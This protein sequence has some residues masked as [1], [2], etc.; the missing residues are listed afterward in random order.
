[1]KNFKLRRS[2]LPLLAAG[3]TLV[4]LSGC[5]EKTE[6][7]KKENLVGYIDTN[8]NEVDP[9]DFIIYDGGNHSRAGKI[10]ATKLEK[11]LKKCKKLGISVGII[12]GSEA[13]IKEEIYE[14]VEFTK[15]IIE[16][17]NIDF[18]VYL[19]PKNIIDNKELSK[20]E[21]ADFIGEFLYLMEQNNIYAGLYGTSTDLQYI[22]ENLLPI[23]KYDSFI[24]EDG[25]EE[26]NGK[27]SVR[28]D[29]R[30]NIQSTY[31]SKEYNDNLAEMIEQNN[32]NRKDSLKQTGYHKVQKEETLRD[33]ADLHNLSESGILKFNEL[34]EDDIKPGITLRIPNELQNE[35]TLIMPKLQR[36]ERAVYRGIDIS[37][38]QDDA[39]NVNFSALRKKIDFII[40]KISEQEPYEN[41]P[42][43]INY[44]K[45]QKDDN[46]DDYYKCCIDNGILVGGYYVTRATTAEEARKE[47]QLVVN[48]IKNLK[49]SLPVFIDYENDKKYMNDFDKIK[50]N[51][52][53]EEILAVA[54]DIFNQNGIRFGLYTNGSTYDQM[55][56]MI[57]QKKLEQNALW[58]A[59]WKGYLYENQVIDNGPRCRTEDGKI[60][61]PCDILQV[62]CT[63][64]D[65]GIGD[66]NGYADMDL[67]FAPFTY[68]NSV[69]VQELPPEYVFETKNYDRRTKLEKAI[70]III[71]VSTPT[72]LGLAYFG[73]AYTVEKR[74][75]RSRQKR[76]GYSNQ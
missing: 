28:N 44:E 16:Q 47:A 55:V 59:C 50:K 57:G 9:E 65:L 43:K 19:N 70:P 76:K 13:K 35:K 15:G 14:D 12:I 53:L 49:F 23:E 25:K 69:E 62:S 6:S 37:H 26:Y 48:E 64:K 4:S 22:N 2:I 51:K 42:D 18:P 8:P 58:L 34:K 45:I 24:I 29:L 10:S 63:I 30:N 33:I 36:E 7:I 61:Y 32:L 74:K 21:K 17:Y 27:S 75:Q 52:S 40:P 54:R 46:F 3:I 68:K 41:Q 73:M 31:K 60:D 66:S 39:K 72:V 11:Y 5:N 56:K 67:C 1:M 38:Y 71:L 20:G